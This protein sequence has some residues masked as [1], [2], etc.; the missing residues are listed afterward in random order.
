MTIHTTIRQY[1]CIVTL[2]ETNMQ[3]FE[4]YTHGYTSKNM[5][6]K[7]PNN[8]IPYIENA[9]LSAIHYTPN[10]LGNRLK[11]NSVLGELARMASEL[12]AWD[13]DERRQRDTIHVV[14]D[15]VADYFDSIGL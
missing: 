14:M 12:D 6:K 8:F 4:N 9:R 2:K 10:D 5:E 3:K 11:V 7:L 13:M 15:F 1:V